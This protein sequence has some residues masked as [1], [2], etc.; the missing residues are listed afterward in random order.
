[1]C[2]CL[3][4]R[5]FLVI[6]KLINVFRVFIF[7]IVAGFVDRFTEFNCKHVFGTVPSLLRNDKPRLPRARFDVC[8]KF[9]VTSREP[10]NFFENLSDFEMFQTQN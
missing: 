1:M 7:C 8:S 6:L 5:R 10:V 2:G 4:V 3:D 9:Q